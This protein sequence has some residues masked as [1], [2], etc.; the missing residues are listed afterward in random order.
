MRLILR[1]IDRMNAALAIV[2]GVL[3]MI[4]TAAVFGQ[5]MVRFVLTAAGINISAPWTEELA[6]Y[7]LIWV[8]FLGAAVGCRKAQLI[9]LEFVVQALPSLPGQMLRYGTLLLCVAFFA[10]MVW[11]GLPF[12]TLGETETSPVMQIP[13]SRVYW[14]MPVGAALM[15]LNT[16]ALMAEAAL[17]GRDIRK[18][19]V[20]ADVE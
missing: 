4:I 20:A 12:V 14:A 18:V 8:V 6:R 5:V 1:M 13:K 19:G 11:V 17:D 7:L 10:M 2:V 9:A 15:I 3:L 16:F